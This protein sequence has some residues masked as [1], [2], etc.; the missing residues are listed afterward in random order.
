MPNLQTEPFL[1][2]DWQIHNKKFHQVS[3]IKKMTTLLND[4]KAKVII[5]VRSHWINT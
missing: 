1:A 3:L 2:L 4:A 5:S